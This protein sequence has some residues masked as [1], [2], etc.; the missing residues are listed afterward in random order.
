MKDNFGLSADLSQLPDT[1]EFMGSLLTAVE[2]RVADNPP[3]AAE[4][5]ASMHPLTLTFHLVAA[6]IANDDGTDRS[7]VNSLGVTGCPSEANQCRR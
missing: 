5:N 7:E 1:A 4:P 2:P 6:G 3:T